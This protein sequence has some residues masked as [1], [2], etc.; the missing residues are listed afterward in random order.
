[1]VLMMWWASV[2]PARAENTPA[3]FP[4]DLIA[5]VTGSNAAPSWATLPRGGLTNA[6]VPFRLDGC[7]AATGLDAAREGDFFPPR[8]A[9]IA[10]GR[11]AARLHLLHG[12]DRLDKDGVP[13][14]EFILHY[15]DGGQRAVRLAHGLHV[16]S[17]VK[18]RH[19]KKAELLDPNSV[20]AWVGAAEE[21]GSLAQRLF[22]T[23]FDNPRPD[24]EIASVEW[25]S[26]FSRSTPLLAAL[27][28]EQGTSAP[29]A[30]LDHSRKI[31]KRA[32]E[33]SGKIFRDEFLIRSVDANDGQAL[34]GASAVLTI[35]DDQGAFY[36]GEARADS[37]GVVHLPYPPQQTLSFIALVRAPGHVPA[38]VRGSQ[39]NRAG[40]QRDI[41]AKLERGVRIGGVALDEAG[42]PVPG[43]SVL[44]YHL[45]KSGAREFTR[46]DFDTVITD[47]NGQW[48]STSLPSECSDFIFEFSHP[49]FRPETRVLSR[50][51]LL[52]GKAPVAMQAAIRVR[53]AVADQAGNPV[54]GAEVRV[55]EMQ[56][57]TGSRVLKTDAKGR[58]SFSVPEP[59]QFFVAVLA[60]GFAPHLEPVLAQPLP[61]NVV[62]ANFTPG[63]D[64][65]PLQWPVNFLSMRLQP[66]K[67]F[68]GRV[69]DQANKPVPGARVRLESWNDTRLLQ[70]QAVA[71]TNGLVTWDALPDGNLLFNVSAPDHGSLGASISG[72][73]T[74]HT[75]TLQ[76]LSRA[77]GRVVDADT[78]KPLPEFTVIRGYAYIYNPGEPLR[79]ERYNPVRGRRGAYSMRLNEYGNGTRSRI[80]IEAPGYM[81]QASVEFTNGGVLTIDFEMKKAKGLAGLVENPDGTPAS[82]ATVVVVELSEYAYM[83]RAGELRRMN[84]Y[85][86]FT[87]TDAAGRFEF[88]PRLEP[89]MIFASTPK[90]FAEVRVTNFLASGKIILQAWGRVRGVVRVGRETDLPVSVR[91]QDQD[92]NYGLGGRTVAPLWLYLK[93]EP[94]EDGDFVF[95]R[96]PPGERKVYL[97]FKLNDRS[98][99]G[100]ATSHGLPVTV[101]PGETVQV[102]F[103]GGR[104]IVGRVEAVTGNPEDVDWRRDVHS[105]TVVTKASTNMPSLNFTGA[106]NSEQQQLMRAE[107][108]RRMVDYWQSPEG[109]AVKLAQRTYVPLF[110]T[111]GTFHIEGVE[112]GDYSFNLN[113]TNPERGDTYSE[114]IGSLYRPVT[115]PA[116]P[117]GK[118]D[119][120]FD[121]GTFQLPIRLPLRVGKRAPQFEVTTTADK[122]VK[123]SD[124]KG[125][126]VLLDFWATWSGSR[127]VDAPA[128]KALHDA[129]EKDGRLVILGLNSDYQTNAFLAAVKAENP[130]WAQAYLGRVGEHPV[131]TAYALQ[132][133]QQSVLVDPEG[134]IAAF[135]LR[136][137]AIRNAV[138]T[139]LGP[140]REP[141]K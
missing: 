21:G 130:K 31:V 121:L 129:Y 101:K 49:D 18:D 16:R 4:V 67:S 111:N 17:L 51:D 88:Q 75:F 69:L 62:P 8:V 20:V 109:R 93:A 44:A 126:Y 37:N 133:Q 86:E 7:V 57:P 132:Y 106:T 43:A 33:S 128:M 60:R 102:V 5:Q 115:V 19:E 76:K 137:P 45:E 14:A 108:N 105:L 123:L 40:M 94:D 91:L 120:T 119:E 58:A 41:S 70:W 124:F 117:P 15:A 34:A 30:P 50:N 110:E 54:E 26:L 39:T 87:R 12:A 122:V 22:R 95:A 10:V 77:H 127:P 96:V 100:I 141:G 25:A 97:Q 56:R 78:K 118:P 80:M 99:G 90:G 104:K 116:A 74:E 32:L 73:M 29:L 71:D 65:V 107:Y 113:V 135:G 136:G 103:G 55:Q 64:P 47:T 138:R 48:S 2:L 3:F 98:N 125:K 134:K 28:L 6:G 24:Q 59:A 63:G 83:E 84:N 9:G 92:F 36:F 79:W 68:R 66:A 112:P 27:T 11:K 42:K 13:V 53:V 61:D 46:T 35:A 139:H 38:L 82:G 89:D 85:G 23:S 131:A 81:P 1:M 140:P 72:S 52:A 114:N